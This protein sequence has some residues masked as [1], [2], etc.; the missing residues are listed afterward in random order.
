MQEW[1]AEETRRY[2]ETL[3]LIGQLVR[4]GFSPIPTDP[5]EPEEPGEQGRMRRDHTVA[6]VERLSS[7]SPQ[8]LSLPL[9]VFSSGPVY[10]HG[11]WA[12][13]L[14][15]EY[16]ED[17]ATQG[18][19]EVFQL[20]QRLVESRAS[21]AEL[22]LALGHIGLLEALCQASGLDSEGVESVRRSLSQGKIAEAKRF[23]LNLGAE[24]AEWLCP[25]SAERW[26]RHLAP[27]LE[28][29][30]PPA[31]QESQRL[32]ALAAATGLSTRWDLSLTGSWPYYTGLVFSLYEV[33]LG[34]ALIKGGRFRVVQGSREFRGV[35]FTLWLDPWFRRPL[36][37]AGGLA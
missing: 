26:Q 2:Q 36:G 14:D 13:S 6:I 7:W 17:G 28:Q 10:E 19:A 9:R 18:E 33:G 1:L 21:Q 12:D 35:G 34:Q 20:I 11:R 15:V 24:W 32:Y 27:W 4:A 8:R 23:L 30:A 37:S 31:A 29:V 3:Q 22:V 5:S 16:V 25:L